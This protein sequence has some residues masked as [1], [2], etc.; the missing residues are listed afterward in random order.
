MEVRVSERELPRGV[1][2]VAEGFW[3][4]RGS[5]KVGGLIELGTQC[6]L[7]RRASG[8]Y[9]LLDAIALSE[10]VARWLDERTDGG[11]AIEAVLHLH[12]FHTLH[13]RGLHERYPRATLYGTARHA[14]RASDLPWASLRTDAPALHALFADDLDFT[15]P[16]GVD[17]ISS[18]ENVHF[19]SVLAIHRASKTLHVDDTLIYARLPFVLRFMG[20][21]TTRFHPTLAKVLERR[22]GAAK[23]FRAWARELVERARDVENLCAAHTHALL[24]RHDTGAPIATRIEQALAKVE[25]VLAAH[26]RKHG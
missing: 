6:S 17:F 16:R 25:P 7:V 3:N 8:K 23:D 14:Q 21:D 19:A 18:D 4:I 11:A 10:P 15:V 2:E 12:P 1:I 9:L 22:A 5:F 26:E 13:V 24:A 20:P